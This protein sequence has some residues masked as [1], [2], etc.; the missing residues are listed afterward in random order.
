MPQKVYKWKVQKALFKIYMPY[1]KC[2]KIGVF[3]YKLKVHIK[4]GFFS[5]GIQRI[6]LSNKK[7]F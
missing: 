2:I 5:K 7:S 3:G 1:F 6:I 4:A